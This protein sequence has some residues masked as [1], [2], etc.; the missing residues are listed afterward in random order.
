MRGRTGGLELGHIINTDR[1]RQSR[2]RKGD[3]Q[4]S[5]S[6]LLFIGDILVSFAFVVFSIVN[7]SKYLGYL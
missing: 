6:E 2:T 7:I 1:Y 5:T 3:L 4:V